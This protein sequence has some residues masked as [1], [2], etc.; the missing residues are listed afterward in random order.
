SRPGSRRPSAP[1]TGFVARSRVAGMLPSPRGESSM[2]A[3]WIAPGAAGTTV[4]LRDTPAPEPKAG[5]L[6]VR[7]RAS[8]LNRGELLG[9]KPGAAAKPGG[10]ECAG[11]VVKTGEGVTG[12]AAGDRV[13]GRSAGGFA[14]QSLMDAR[15]AMKVP[16]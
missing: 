7:V 1:C 4:E 12:F 6:L 3:Y 5:E 11:E 13:M 10:G 15:E 8:S 14:E 9:G 16:A 2:K